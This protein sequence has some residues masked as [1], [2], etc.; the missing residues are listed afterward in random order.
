MRFY[1][2]YKV[3]ESERLKIALLFSL[4]LHALLLFFIRFAPPSWKNLSSL[5]VPLQVTLEKKFTR[6]PK[7]AGIPEASLDS[8]GEARVGVQ[9]ANP[10]PQKT[11]T[12]VTQTK[13]DQPRAEIPKTF[14][15]EKILTIKK[16]AKITMVESEPDLLVVKSPPPETPENE[17]KP[18][19][20]TPSV[21]NPVASMVPPIEKLVSPEPA[22]GEKQ[23]KIIVAEPAQEK[24]AVEKPESNAEEPKPAKIEEP[25]PVKTEEPK[26]VKVAEPEPVKI[27]EPE[28]VKMAEPEP[29]KIEEPKPVKVAEPEPVKIKEP[30]PAKIEEPKLAKAEEPKPIKTE[31]PKPAK[32][33]EQAPAQAESPRPAGNEAV[34]ESRTQSR[35]DVSDVFR[36]RPSGYAMPSLSEQSIA[37]VRKLSLGEDKKIKFGE[38]RKTVDFKEQDLRYALYIEGLRLKLERIGFFNYPAAAAKNN[39]S[40]SLSIRISVRRDGS[41]EDFSI[42][43]PSKHDALNAG[44]EK[45]VRMSAPF[46]PLPENIRQETDILSITIN[47]TFSNSRQSLD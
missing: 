39:L 6:I 46:S 40:G 16:P 8:K 1:L 14:N 29:V 3:S 4:V 42:V 13:V 32:A 2:N 38:R 19:A 5:T 34:A 10:F 30:E 11:L 20:P 17:E 22:P 23:E 47:W 43:W 36:A 31:E 27:E 33:A 45:I 21:E 41:L 35:G 12:A 25:E 28:P 7:P 26:P 44:A 18:F 24:L 9:E 15:R 37:S